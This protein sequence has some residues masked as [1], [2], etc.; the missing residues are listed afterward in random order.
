MWVMSGDNEVS[1]FYE[2]NFKNEA[3]IALARIFLL[4]NTL[5]RTNVLWY[6]YSAHFVDVQNGE[7][8]IESFEP[9]YNEALTNGET[10]VCT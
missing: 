2:L 9:E 6:S 8:E 1:I 3:D 5:Y 10:G 4:T 7:Q